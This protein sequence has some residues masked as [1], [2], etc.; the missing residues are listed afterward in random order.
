MAKDVWPTYVTLHLRVFNPLVRL[1]GLL[2]VAGGA[3]SIAWGVYSFLHP[4]LPTP[5]V[6]LTSSFAVD[7]LVIGAF[8]LIIGAAFLAVR[9]W[10]PD[11][12]GRIG[13]RWSWWTGEPK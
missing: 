13:T 4:D 6:I 12:T 9:P 2:A 8:C 10:R 7:R 3:G 11:L 5:G 1:F